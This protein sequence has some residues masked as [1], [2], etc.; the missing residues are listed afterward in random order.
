MAAVRGRQLGTKLQHNRYMSASQSW[1]NYQVQ[2]P[3]AVLAGGSAANR[4]QQTP[5]AHVK[6]AQQGLPDNACMMTLM[7]GIDDSCGALA[8]HLVTSDYTP[9]QPAAPARVDPGEPSEDISPQSAGSPQDARIP[10]AT[11]PSPNGTLRR[12]PALHAR[13]FRVAV[14]AHACVALPA[15]RHAL[16]PWLITSPSSACPPTG[17]QELRPV[18]H[19]RTNNI[20]RGAVQLGAA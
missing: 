8:V 18:Q 14:P 3:R 6:H 13:L 19:T 17:G 11:T 10:T 5:A 16:T 20:T 1:Q 7:T 4:A 2:L 12:A 9:G 15:A